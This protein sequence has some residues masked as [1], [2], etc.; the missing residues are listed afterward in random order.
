MEADPCRVERLL[1]LTSRSFALSI[2]LLPGPLRTQVG[3]GYLVFRIA[4]TLEDE[5]VAGPE[6][7]VAALKVLDDLLQR[8]DACAVG[9]LLSD[10]SEAHRPDDGGYAE[11]LSAG[12]WVVERLEGLSPAA[13][14][15]IRHH[16]SRTIHGMV[17][18][19]RCPAQGRDVADLQDY[20][21]RVAGIVGEMLTDLFVEHHPPLGPHH[22]VLTGLSRGFGEAL[23]LVNILRDQGVDLAAGRRY[24]PDAATRQQLLELAGEGCAQ[25]H[26]YIDQMKALDCPQGVVRFNTLNL[27]LAQATL[28]LIRTSGPGV[29]VP[30]GVVADLLQS[31]E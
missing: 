22:A 27:Q 20:C 10:W 19:L 9:Q 31:L 2:P 28:E 26:A 8:G 7:R 15:A 11:L 18:R 21:Y 16:V 3:V 24:V 5:G 17:E 23:Q 12:Q 4:D 30:R 14:K 1:L 6:Q 13:A 29:K 25:A